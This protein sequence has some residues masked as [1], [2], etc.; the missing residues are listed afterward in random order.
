MP[1]SCRISPHDRAHVP[2][3]LDH[4]ACAGLALGADHRGPL[5][6]AAEGLAEVPRAA[7][8]RDR[9]PGLIDMVFLVRRRQDLGLVDH[10]HTQRL[11][12]PRL[13][14]VPDPDLAHHR[15]RDRVD[16]LG[17]LLRVG[18]PGYP[19]HLPDLGRDPLEGHDGDGASLLGDSGL[20]GV[21]HVHDHAPLLHRGEAALDE[22]GPEPQLLEF[23]LRHILARA[24]H[25]NSAPAARS[26]V[27]MEAARTALMIAGPA[28]ASGRSGVPMT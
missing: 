13:D 24:A 20:V 25:K 27:P 5:V 12:D 22:L 23:H 14:R 4:V 11:E 3:G 7:D 2:D 21:D 8:E 6:Y 10:V 15:D 17:D 28:P 18:H 9:E 16:D 19:S 1:E 26:A